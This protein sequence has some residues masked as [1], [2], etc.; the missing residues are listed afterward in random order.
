M[1]GPVYSRLL[2]AYVGVGSAVAPNSFL[3]L[4][5]DKSWMPSHETI[6]RYD[7]HP[8]QFET[9]SVRAPL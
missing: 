1:Y 3:I 5:K 4:P 7:D 6:N 8:A 9:M 2:L